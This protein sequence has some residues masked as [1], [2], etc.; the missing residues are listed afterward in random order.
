MERTS[1][2]MEH[3]DIYFLSPGGGGDLKQKQTKKQGRILKKYRGKV[4]KGRKEEG[5]RKL[6]KGNSSEKKRE[7]NLIFSPA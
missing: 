3:R 6:K 7:T 5:K 1:N 2:P 4:K